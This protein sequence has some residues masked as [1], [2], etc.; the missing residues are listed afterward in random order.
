MN[1]MNQ[2]T[3]V[4]DVL[5]S[6][7]PTDANGTVAAHT[8]DIVDMANYHRAFIML[9]AGEAAQGAT[10]DVDV[11]E[12]SD[13]ACA[14]SQQMTAKSITQLDANDSGGYVGIEIQSEEMDV[15]D[16]FHYLKVIV[17]VGSATY[18]YDLKILGFV[19]RFAP[20]GVTDFTELVE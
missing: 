16:G 3:E 8:S 5:E 2:F 7:A 6:M 1:A 11:Y 10:I 20:C 17:T 14:T 18:T 9:T 12:C 19:P 13:S 15:E 4:V